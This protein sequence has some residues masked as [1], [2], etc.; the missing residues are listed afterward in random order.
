MKAHRLAKYFPILEGEEFDLLVEDIRK[1]GQLEPIV[2]VDGEIL[3]GVNRYAACQKLGIEPVTK[4]YQGTDPL[5]YVIS[6]NIR[7]RHM[8]VSQRSMLAQ[9]MLPEFEKEAKERQREGEI[10]GGKARQEIG[11]VAIGPK[12]PQRARDSVATLFGVSGQTIQR[13]KRI[14]AEAPEKVDDIIKGKTTVGAVDEEISLRK[15]VADKAKKESKK[16][17]KIPAERPKAV[18]E[19]FE[20]CAVFKGA[21]KLAVAAAQQDMFSEEAKRFAEQKHDALRALMDKV[22]S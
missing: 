12:E 20:A 21:L 1:N 18:K 13:A 10:K 9:E 4:E 11:H 14:K 22:V 3:D 2:T 17:K 15:Y 19:Y 16:A 7:R 6:E 5:G 8:D